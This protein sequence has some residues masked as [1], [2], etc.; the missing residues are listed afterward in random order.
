MAATVRLCASR[1]SAARDAAGDSATTQAAATMT[2]LIGRAIEGKGIDMV[3]GV[4]WMA[5]WG[6]AVQVW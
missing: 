2:R 1:R 5:S 3:S 4:L 6:D